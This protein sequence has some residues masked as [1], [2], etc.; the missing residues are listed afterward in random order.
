[1]CICVYINIYQSY[2]NNINKVIMFFLLTHVSNVELPVY[3][4]MLQTKH[5][6]TRNSWFGV[7]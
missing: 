7:W 5:N 1:M 6:L 3:I 4:W 2:R